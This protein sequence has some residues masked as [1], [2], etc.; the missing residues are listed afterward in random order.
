VRPSPQRRMLNGA[1]SRMTNRLAKIGACE[2][3]SLHNLFQGWN[4]LTYVTQG[5]SLTRNPG[6]TAV[7]P[8]GSIQ[9]RWRDGVDAFSLKV[10]PFVNRDY[11]TISASKMYHSS[12]SDPVPLL[13]KRRY[14][15]AAPSAR[16]RGLK[17]TSTFERSLTRAPAAGR[18]R[19]RGLNVA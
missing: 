2:E 16:N 6:L 7:T 18:H 5:S 8:L 13:F 11:P 4:V 3:G 10:A 19:D 9:V 12:S 17:P 14:A 15:T 1:H